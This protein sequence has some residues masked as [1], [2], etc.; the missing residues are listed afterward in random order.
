MRVGDR[1]KIIRNSMW[2]EYGE[3]GN[4]IAQ[5]RFSYLIEFRKRPDT[6]AYKTYWISKP[7]VVKLNVCNN[8][9]EE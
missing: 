8:Y 3:V 2:A 5:D 6:K 9:I 7:E 4:I 1:V